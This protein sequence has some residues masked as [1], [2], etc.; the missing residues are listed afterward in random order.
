MAVNKVVLGNE[1]LI[2]LS[3]ITLSSASKVAEGKTVHLSNGERATGTATGSIE[4]E[5]I[6]DK[7]I[8]SLPSS[9]AQMSGNKLILG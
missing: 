3:V 9:F 5:L 2:D 7:A 6:G 8:I 4:A 1:T